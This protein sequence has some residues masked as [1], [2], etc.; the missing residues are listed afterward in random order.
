M[1]ASLKARSDSSY[2]IGEREFPFRLDNFEQ[3]KSRIYQL[4]GISLGSHKKDLV[5]NRLVRRIRALGLDSFDQYLAYLGDSKDEVGH[6]VNA[7][8]TNLTSFFRE[9]HHFDF[10]SQQYIPELEAAGQRKLRV[11]SSACSVGD[12]PYS[13]AI[14]LLESGIELDKWDIKIF[15]TDSDTNVL[16][17]A[18]KGVYGINRVDDLSKMRVR[19]A[20]LRGKGV[21][22][23]KVMVKKHLRAMI[24]FKYCNLIKDWMFNAPLDIIFCRNVMIYF[25]KKTQVELLNR[26][27]DL[28]KPG[29]ILC[30]GHSESP[31]RSMKDYKLLGRTMYQKL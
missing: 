4:A 26:M 11:W 15:A 24:D 8:T 16:A 7:L 3:I 5:Y 19:S 17:T 28:L 20:F 6:F 18:K 12:E 21:N 31:T 30:I 9:E 1:K 10:M 25:D 29:G 2:N 13:M 23:D 14:S 27:T 22:N